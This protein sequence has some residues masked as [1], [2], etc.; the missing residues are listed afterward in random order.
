MTIGQ[1]EKITYRGKLVRTTLSESFLSPTSGVGY[2]LGDGLGIAL[3]HVLQRG[4]AAHRVVLR[5]TGTVVE[6]TSVSVTLELTSGRRMKIRIPD[7]VR[8]Q[9]LQ[10]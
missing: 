8:R 6:E 4:N 5:A 2:G 10:P 7:I 1:K 3:H 9:I